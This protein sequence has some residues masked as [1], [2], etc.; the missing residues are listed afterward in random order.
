MSLKIEDIE[1]LVRWTGGWK[2]VYVK[3]KGE[4]MKVRNGSPT[5]EFW[6][7]WREKKDEI[8]SL[9]ISVRKEED[10]EEETYNWVITAWS[11]ASEGEKT[12]AK[13]DWNKKMAQRN[14]NKD[15]EEED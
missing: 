6:D 4:H 10:E 8:K 11:E 1:K 13:D 3:S 12:K 15:H 9:G 7:L 5:P 2:V 14:T